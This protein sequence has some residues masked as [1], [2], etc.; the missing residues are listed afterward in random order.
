MKLLNIAFVNIKRFIKTPQIIGVILMQV[1][2]IFM[3]ATDSGSASV[4]GLGHIKII[5]KDTGVYS[6]KLIDSLR[7]S[8][9]IDILQNEDGI[10]E[11]DIIVNIN[12]NYSKLLEQGIK[13]TVEVKGTEGDGV[14]LSTVNHIEKFNNEEL[15]GEFIENY[16]KDFFAFKNKENKEETNPMMFAM[17]CYFM[18]IGGSMISEDTMK[19]KQGNVL[20]RALTTA[21]S[22]YEIIGGLF[23]GMLILQGGLTSIIFITASRSADFGINTLSAVGIILSFSALSTSI[24]LFT[25]RVSKNPALASIIGVVYT[26]IAFLF[27]FL[28]MFQVG[29]SDI[30]EKIAILFPFHWVIK[31]MTG[32]SVVVSIGMILLMAGVF[33][34]AGGFKYKNFISTL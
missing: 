31:A 18:L 32:G 13:P 25:T 21:N 20:K 26:V 8:Y 12:E 1:V 11:G 5:N 10:E 30:I 6:E 34:T 19:L 9:G 17:L 7:D 28:E 14:V 4:S 22:S 3:F 2:F 33:F 16:N 23:L 29:A 15:K 27:M 24:C